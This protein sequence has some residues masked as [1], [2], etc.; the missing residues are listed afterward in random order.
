MIIRWKNFIKL[1]YIFC[2]LRDNSLGRSYLIEHGILLWLW[3]FFV[4]S[5]NGLRKDFSPKTDLTEHRQVFKPVTNL[6]IHFT[7]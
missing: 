7:L 4:S 2:I 1:N 6:H 3:P 5:Q